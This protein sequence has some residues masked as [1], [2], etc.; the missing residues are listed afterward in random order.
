[1]ATSRRVGVLSHSTEVAGLTLLGIPVVSC[2]A[3][4]HCWVSVVVPQLS[5][6]SLQLVARRPLH[7]L[8]A[9]VLSV[10]AACPRVWSQPLPIAPVSCGA[11]VRAAVVCR[12]LYALLHAV[13]EEDWAAIAPAS[14]VRLSCL[15][16]AA[17]LWSAG[18][19]SSMPWMALACCGCSWVASALSQRRDQIAGRAARAPAVTVLCCV[20]LCMWCFGQVAW[21]ARRACEE[22]GVQSVWVV[23][24]TPQT[25]PTA[26]S[27][28]CC[29]AACF[30][31]F[32]QLMKHI[33]ECQRK[34]ADAAATESPAPSADVHAAAPRSDHPLS[35]DGTPRSPLPIAKREQRRGSG[36]RDSHEGSGAGKE[37][38]TPAKEKPSDETQTSPA[39][40]D[41]PDDEAEE[42]D[43]SGEGDDD[44]KMEGASDE[45]KE[46]RKSKKKNQK[47]SDKSAAKKAI[48][49]LT[50]ACPICKRSWKE[51]G[52]ANRSGPSRGAHK[53]WCARRKGIGKIGLS[54][55]KPK[56]LILVKKEGGGG[57]ADAWY[58]EMCDTQ[59][60]K[61]MFKS[62]WAFGWHK[63]KCNGT[64]NRAP[65]A[66]AAAAASQGATESD[67]DTS[68]EEDSQPKRNARHE[69][70]SPQRCASRALDGSIE[71]QVRDK[72]GERWI[73]SVELHKSHPLELLRLYES[74][75]AFAPM[76]DVSVSKARKGT[77]KSIEVF[78]TS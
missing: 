59:F 35:A 60:P 57:L 38:H 43:N 68:S 46:S 26:T 73:P 67:S 36:R 77:A 41:N 14:A 45:P 37:D 75:P 78:V 24:L 6:W 25:Q 66:A 34:A 17:I 50:T 8:Y 5:L 16:G 42:S 29:R 63:R 51:L 71:V 1:M 22:D 62:P 40:E 64:R 74:Q 47:N 18:S 48:A 13:V 61:R 65:A 70:R 4:A 39:K 55:S 23:P 54:Q 56:S 3:S 30:S 28:P 21:E 11:A 69:A 58:C 52:L 20:S 32:S 33:S 9:L 10:T 31:D 53:R 15:W 2:T 7:L 49:P 72:E 44:D 27:C 76:D 19:M 12:A